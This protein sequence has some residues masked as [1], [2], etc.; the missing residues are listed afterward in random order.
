[1]CSGVRSQA[2]PP[3]LLFYTS[4]SPTGFTQNI[5]FSTD[6][7]ESFRPYPGNPVVPTMG[8]GDDRDPSIACDPERVYQAMF[9]DKK[10]LDGVLRFVFTPVTGRAEVRK[11]EGP[12][13]RAVLER[14]R[15]A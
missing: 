2:T 8:D 7:G 11:V 13:V 3:I 10:A 6:G 15:N 14:C 4:A 9:K 1:M 5:A 12:L